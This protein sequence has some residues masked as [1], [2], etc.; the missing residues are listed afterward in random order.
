MWKIQKLTFQ[1][2]EFKTCSLGYKITKKND[3]NSI[4]AYTLRQAELVCKLLNNNDQLAEE[5]RVCQQL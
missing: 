4:Y 5:I 1:D 3:E 2:L